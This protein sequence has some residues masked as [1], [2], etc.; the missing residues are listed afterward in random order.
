MPSWWYCVACLD[1]L[2]T[3]DAGVEATCGDTVRFYPWTID[4]KYYSAEVN[5]CVVPSKFLVTA[6][7]AESVQALVIYFDSTQVSSCFQGSLH[8]HGGVTGLLFLLCSLSS[9]VCPFM[10][11]CFCPCRNRVLTVSP[12]GSPWQKR[13]YLR[14]WSWS[15]IECVKLV[16]ASDMYPSVKTVYIRVFSSSCY[17]MKILQDLCRFQPTLR[18]SHLHLCSLFLDAFRMTM[19]RRPWRVVK[20]GGVLR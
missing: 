15:V 16:R 6:E 19:T 2:G 5:L 13:G 9:S 10:F 20:V 12:H 18:L 17:T 3:E 4:N 8:S 1:I 7:I 11:V 14:W